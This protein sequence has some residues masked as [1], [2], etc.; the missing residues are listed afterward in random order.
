[1]SRGAR[2]AAGRSRV[3]PRRPTERCDSDPS[4]TESRRSSP[5][6]SSNWPARRGVVELLDVGEM[7]AHLRRV[8]EQPVRQ[9]AEDVRVV[10]ARRVRE[11]EVTPFG[12]ASSKNASSDP[13]E[14]GDPGGEVPAARFARPAAIRDAAQ[15]DRRNARRAR[16]RAAPQSLPSIRPARR[17][18]ARRRAVASVDVTRETVMPRSAAKAFGAEPRDERRSPS[19]PCRRRFIP[20][21]KRERRAVFRAPSSIASSATMTPSPIRGGAVKRAG[22]AGVDDEP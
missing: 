19:A 21:R 18:R 15:L 9:C 2:P 14:P 22:E 16:R 7:D 6:S 20:A 10:G 8:V 13:R 12:Q 5:S 11:R 17:A 3:R 4:E 1:M